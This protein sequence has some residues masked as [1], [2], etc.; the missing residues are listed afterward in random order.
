M[1]KVAEAL[2][3]V[4]AAVADAR[5]RGEPIELSVQPELDV[6]SFDPLLMTPLNR[7]SNALGSLVL[8]GFSCRVTDETP[9]PFAV[10]RIDDDRMVAVGMPTSM[11]ILDHTARVL[12]MPAFWETSASDRV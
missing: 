7:R 10:F 3:Q 2:A 11:G 12:G 6:W 1:S 8:Y 9:L 4:N 5:D